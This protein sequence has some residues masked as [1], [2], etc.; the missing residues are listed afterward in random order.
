MLAETAELARASAKTRTTSFA[1]T[2]DRRLQWLRECARPPACEPWMLDAIVDGA[3][4]EEQM[5]ALRVSFAAASEARA[6]AANSEELA[7][8]AASSI[9]GIMSRPG[10][11]LAL[12]DEMPVTTLAS[13][14]KSPELARGKV[15]K[16]TGRVLELRARD[17][18]QS[19]GAL[20]VEGK[21]IVRFVAALGTKGLRVGA[22]AT[23]RG[24]LLR[25]DPD[26]TTN[27]ATVSLFTVGAFE[28]PEKR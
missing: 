12:L 25:R 13:A 16:L 11:G 20:A 24:V 10:M 26:A 18:G 22:S 3:P 19:E 14:S 17:S 8:D 28:M 9:A 27:A 2:R 1:M 5:R 21:T 23:Y 15:L 7:A 4:P 6:R